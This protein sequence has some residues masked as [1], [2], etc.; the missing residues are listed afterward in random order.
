MKRNGL[1]IALVMAMTLLFNFDSFSQEKKIK[2]K[3]I[4][5][6]ELKK[7]LLINKVERVHFKE[8]VEPKIRTKHIYRTRTQVF[9]IENRE[10]VQGPIPKIDK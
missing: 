5:T 10:Y 4:E 1:T 3:D 8:S 2:I 6:Y 7:P 9:R